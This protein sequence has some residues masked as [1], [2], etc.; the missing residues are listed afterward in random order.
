MRSH[1][2]ASEQDFARLSSAEE[3]RRRC[4]EALTGQSGTTSSTSSS[5]DQELACVQFLTS[6]CLG[7]S[8]NSSSSTSVSLYSIFVQ[9]D[10]AEPTLLHLLAQR[11]GNTSP[12]MRTRILSCLNAFHMPEY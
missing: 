5:A 4:R 10:G 6:R 2:P 11:L 1:V 12:D 8:S 7:S 9:A 3:I